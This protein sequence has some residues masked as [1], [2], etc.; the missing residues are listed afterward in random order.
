MSFKGDT[1]NGGKRSKER[2]TVMVCASMIGESKY[3][4]WL[5]VNLRIPD[6]SRR[7]VLFLSPTKQI[8]G[9]GMDDK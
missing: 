3:L 5:L 9:H 7:Y 2:I 6:A 8:H 1:W 4:S